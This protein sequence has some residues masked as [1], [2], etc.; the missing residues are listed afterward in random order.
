MFSLNICSES[1][2]WRQTDTAQEKSRKERERERDGYACALSAN[3]CL[4]LPDMSAIVLSSGNMLHPVRRREV[5]SPTLSNCTG[6]LPSSEWLGLDICQER[7]KG[8]VVTCFE[9]TCQHS[10]RSHG[11]SNCS[12]EQISWHLL[13][14]Y[15]NMGPSDGAQK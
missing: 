13:T 7:Q 9:S 5:T 12:P 14:R 6:R 4:S 1:D 3:L 2:K 15:K 11:S 10:R 8:V